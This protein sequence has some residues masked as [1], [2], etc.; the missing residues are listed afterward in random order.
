MV[1]YAAFQITDE[2]MITLVFIGI[3]DAE[4]SLSESR[5]IV[6]EG[7]NSTIT[8]C[9][10][11]NVGYLEKSVLLTLENEGNLFVAVNVGNNGTVIHDIFC[12]SQ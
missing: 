4:F 8:I 3:S 7:I 12:I 1:H 11:L 10:V 6:T 9:V 2:N 5:Y